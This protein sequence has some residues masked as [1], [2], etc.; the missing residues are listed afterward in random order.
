MT[1]PQRPTPERDAAIA[2]LSIVATHLRTWAATSAAMAEEAAMDRPIQAYT[3]A[4]VQRCRAAT[5]AEA[6]ALVEA[7]I[8]ILHE[9]RASTIP[10]PPALDAMHLEPPV[11]PGRERS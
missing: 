1:A 8:R 9:D 7:G 2:A 6:L 10:A 5:V 11:L 4:D 3:R